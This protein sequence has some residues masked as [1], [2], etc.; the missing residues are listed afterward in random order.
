MKTKT[1]LVF[2]FEREDSSPVVKRLTKEEILDLSKESHY[3]DFMVIDGNIVK[4]FDQRLNQ[5]QLVG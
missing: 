4:S 3:G 2:V 1:Y 5:N